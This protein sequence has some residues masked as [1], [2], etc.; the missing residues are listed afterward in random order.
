MSR[1][2]ISRLA[3]TRFAVR[4]A[5]FFSAGAAKEQ[6]EV[7]ENQEPVIEE[8]E[9]SQPEQSLEE[10]MKQ[11]KEQLAEKH[12]T[13]LRCLAE[14]DNLRKRTSKEIANARKFAVTGFAE[15]VLEVND[16]LVRATESVPAEIRADDFEEEDTSSHRYQLRMLYDG[17][18]MTQQLL[19]GVLSRN[20]VHKIDTNGAFDPNKHEA[21]MQVPV[22]D[23]MP[24]EVGH[25]A[26]VMR[27]G[28]TIHDRVL[29]SAQVAVFSKPE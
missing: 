5:R 23:V 19:E 25:I 26:Y 28:F 1:L 21:L 29:R 13:L 11:L 6:E 15:S 17:M 10:Q 16:T 22:S 2:V 8:Q 7:A 27:T 18:T 20:H 12:D 4:R 14:Q 24:G 3:A 9:E